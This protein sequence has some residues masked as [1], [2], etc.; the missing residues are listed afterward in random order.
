MNAFALE[1]EGSS[2]FFPGGKA[3]A[4]VSLR[5]RPGTV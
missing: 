3:L 1:A 5:V 2:K 4:K